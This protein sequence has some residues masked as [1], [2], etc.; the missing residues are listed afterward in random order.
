MRVLLVSTYEL[1]HQPLHVAYAGKPLASHDACWWTVKVWDQSGNASEWSKPARWTMG[2]LDAKDWEPARWIG[3]DGGDW[4]FDFYMETKNI[5]FATGA[6]AIA[7][8]GG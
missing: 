1:G 7:K 3:R 6:H 2:L 8:L 5:A 4:S